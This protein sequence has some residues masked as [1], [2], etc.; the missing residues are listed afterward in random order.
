MLYHFSQESWR[1]VEESR[2]QD[3]VVVAARPAQSEGVP[4]TCTLTSSHHVL[5]SSGL[6]AEDGQ[7]G[8]PPTHRHSRRGAAAVQPASELLLSAAMMQGI[9]PLL[10]IF[11]SFPLPRMLSI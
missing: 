4:A 9:L 1:Q 3:G 6:L 8:G 5:L 11:L 7:T 10:L 2:H